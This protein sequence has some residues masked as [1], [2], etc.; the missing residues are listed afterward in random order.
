MGHFQTGAPKM[1]L[2]DTV[3]SV[4]VSQTRLFPQI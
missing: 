3:K 1:R 2:L 4:E